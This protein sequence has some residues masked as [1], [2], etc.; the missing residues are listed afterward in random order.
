MITRA[1][2]TR[3]DCPSVYVA[4]CEAVTHDLD[5]IWTGD[6]PSTTKTLPDLRSKRAIDLVVKAADYIEQISWA[7]AWAHPSALPA[8]LAHTEP[9]YT[10]VADE[11]A[12]R[13]GSDVLVYLEEIRRELEQNDRFV[14][15]VP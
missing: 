8:I 11:L 12:T 13:Y 2:M 3:I 1:L 9:R 5:E 15:T 14:P 7:K 4:V 6:H 10:A